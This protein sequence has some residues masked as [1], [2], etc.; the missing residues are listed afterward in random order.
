MLRTGK[1]VDLAS[2]GLYHRI[3]SSVAR[4]PSVRPK[5]GLGSL[6]TINSI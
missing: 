5:G 4:V 2:G 3:A 6:V 1:V